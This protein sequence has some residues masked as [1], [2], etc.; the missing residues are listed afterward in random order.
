MN[1]LHLSPDART[2]LAEIREYIS[3]ELE[4]PSAAES[5]IARITKGIRILML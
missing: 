2:D 3:T 1:K 4:N 5:T